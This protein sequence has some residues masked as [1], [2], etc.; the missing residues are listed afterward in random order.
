MPP[1]CHRSVVFLRAGGAAEHSLATYA[2]VAQRLAELL[3]LPFG[4]V[5]A[6]SQLSTQDIYFVPDETLSCATAATLGIRSERDL[7]GGVVPYPFVATKCVSHGL[8]SPGA[9]CPSGWEPDLGDL[10]EGIVL[11]GYTVFDLD[12]AIEAVNRLGR[13][14]GAIRLKL[15]SAMGGV[16]Q[17]THRSVSEAE[18]RLH[19][20]PADTIA[21]EGLV[22]EAD[23]NES[24]TWSVGTAR[25]GDLTGA[26]YGHQRTTTD[27]QGRTV[28]GGSTLHVL[29]GSWEELLAAAMPEPAREAV[30]LASRYHEAMTQAF[31]ALIA[32]RCNYDVIM[33]HDAAGRRLSAVLEQSWRIGGASGAEIAALA[34]FR[35]D[36]SLASVKA[37]THESYGAHADL[38]AGARVQF[39]GIDPD[40][41]QIL[42]FVCTDLDVHH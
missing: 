30:A 40:A 10:L 35:V 24:A 8:V 25:V 17:S 4:G 2:N 27:N 38:P 37:S 18:A 39:D 23:I 19:D 33:G 11:P 1:K 15:P 36:P 3:E 7:F 20:M 28:Y 14:C 5:L 26:Y 34:A 16:G 29:P 21:R 6:S 41:G 12:D 31:P 13:Q 42:K 9:V 32:S 22:I